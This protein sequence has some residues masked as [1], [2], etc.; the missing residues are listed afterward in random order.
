MLP[1]PGRPPLQHGQMACLDQQPGSHLALIKG[2]GY[3][4]VD[5]IPV[6]YGNGEN[7]NVM[8]KELDN[9]GEVCGNNGYGRGYLGEKM[10]LVEVMV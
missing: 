10:W 6:Y 2:I 1:P 8:T 9:V 7:A 4:N 3:N 5:I